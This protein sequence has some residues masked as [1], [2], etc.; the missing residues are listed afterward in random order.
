MVIGLEN[1]KVKMK[2]M[3]KK[4]RKRVVDLEAS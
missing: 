1:S 4:K 3:S 2:A